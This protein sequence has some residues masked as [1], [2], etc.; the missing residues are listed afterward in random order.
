MKLNLCILRSGSHANCTVLWTENECL[1]IDCGR[2]EDI[3]EELASLGVRP[4]MVKALLIT[5]A[6]GDHIDDKALKFALQL[7][8]PLYAHPGT[9]K[10]IAKKYGK[11]RYPESLLKDV[12]AGSADIGPF[13]VESFDLD[14]WKDR[15][16]IAGRTVGF[17]LTV[18]DGPRKHKIG[19]ATDTRKI[20]PATRSFLKDSHTLIIEANYSEEYIK[21]IVPHMGYEEHLGNQ[22]T[23]K[24]IS[25]IHKDSTDD[26]ALRTV[27]LAHISD[28]NNNVNLALE[29]VAMVLG[30]K[31]PGITIHPTFRYKRTDVHQLM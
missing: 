11:I 7:K 30:K 16:F 20:G 25:R 9:F 13:H 14:H 3:Q 29:E 10:R 27:F 17:A 12:S 19:F 15:P 4:P 23:G 18:S 31:H 22:A 1:L 21:T 26:E 2:V 28:T 5:H 24:A 6:H 8:I